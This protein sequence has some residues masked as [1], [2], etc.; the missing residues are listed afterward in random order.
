M[1]DSAQ[2]ELAIRSALPARSRSR[3]KTAL[4][5]DILLVIGSQMSVFFYTLA[6]AGE[7]TG[8]IVAIIYTSLFTVAVVPAVEMFFVTWLGTT[9]GRALLGLSVRPARTWTSTGVAAA[10]PIQLRFFARIIDAGMAC[11]LFGGIFFVMAIV[12][13]DLSAAWWKTTV[14]CFFL[15]P[16]IEAASTHAYGATPGKRRMGL[17]IVDARYPNERLSLLR[18]G[19]RSYVV[20][21][22]FA[23]WWVLPIF[24]WGWA[25]ADQQRRGLHDLAAGTWVTKAPS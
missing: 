6:H 24:V 15:L 14:L 5:I 10:A 1:T 16:A 17:C 3:H 18:C 4:L 12:V 19:V 22:S 23:V 8:G 20:W 13:D 2:S 7:E 11:V 25:F 9:P 21:F